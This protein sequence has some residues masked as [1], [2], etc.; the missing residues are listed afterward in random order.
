MKIL[1]TGGT[2][3][4]GRR[5]VNT[6]KK[7]HQL[8]VLS[9]Q[10]KKEDDVS[11]YSWDALSGDP[12]PS[13]A[14]KGIEGVINLMG[15]NLA[16][17]R[18]SPR[19]KKKL[20][21][22]R[23]AG[24]RH[25]LDSLNHR[26]KFF[27]SAGA[28]GIYPVNQ[29]ESITEETPPGDGFLSELCQNWEKEVKKLQL[30]DRM[31]QLRIGVVL[32]KGGGALKKMLTPFRLGLGG[33]IGSGRQMMSWIHLDDLVK[34]IVSAVEND[35]YQGVY[36]AVAPNPVS[37]KEF[38]KALGKALRRPTLFPVPAAILNML[39]GEMSQLLLGSQKILP[40]RL[41]DQGHSFLYPN[42][43][44]ALKNITD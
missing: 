33:T 22:S 14:L 17:K 26:L 40:Q 41:L 29:Y 10:E 11:F 23:I 19:Q 6:L 24:T 44:D 5:L 12:V 2:G 16:A 8:V 27:I 35:S 13:E 32:E 30:C 3:F 1:I 43:E 39:M 18:W 4:V 36:N 34:I 28:I 31:V 7:K 37:N 42:M 21:D 25:F 20:R 9:R 15:E 38:T